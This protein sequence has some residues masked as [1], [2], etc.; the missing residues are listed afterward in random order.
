MVKSDIIDKLED[1]EEDMELVRKS[2]R[3]ETVKMG[4]R[5]KGA[6]FAD[7]EIESSK[8]KIFEGA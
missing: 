5:L 8:S 2:L 3:G 7:E 4:G 1:A 6:K